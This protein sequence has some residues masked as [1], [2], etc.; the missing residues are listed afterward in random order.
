[1]LRKQRRLPGKKNNR[2]IWWSRWKRQ[3]ISWFQL[4]RMVVAHRIRRSTRYQAKTAGTT[5]A[6]TGFQILRICTRRIRS[7]CRQSR[8]GLFQSLEGLRRMQRLSSVF[9]FFRISSAIRKVRIW[10][11]RADW[12]SWSTFLRL[13]RASK[14]CPIVLIP[15]AALDRASKS[16]PGRS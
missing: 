3:W 15:L 1:M 7:S 2:A 12:K 11:Q 10:I 16:D 4:R 9:R 13:M 14:S 8:R 6:L 5:K